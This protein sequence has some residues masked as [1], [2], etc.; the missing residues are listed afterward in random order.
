MVEKLLVNTLHQLVFLKITSIP[1]TLHTFWDILIIC[2]SRG[3]FF[4]VWCFFYVEE[5][6][7]VRI[8]VQAP[9]SS[10]QHLYESEG[11]I[12]EK[13]KNNIEITM[14]HLM[15]LVKVVVGAMD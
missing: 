4:F 3:S 7:T 11:N 12:S 2:P 14:K 9:L 5:G 15:I 6:K 13:K 10:A 1:N 8:T